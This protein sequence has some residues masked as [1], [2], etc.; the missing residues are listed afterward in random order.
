MTF[1]YGMTRKGKDGKYHFVPYSF[2][3]EKLQKFLATLVE[4][5]T[6]VG[7]EKETKQRTILQ[8]DYYWGGI[9][10]PIMDWTG[11]TKN[12]VHEILGSEFLIAYKLINGKEKPYIR[13]TTDL[14]TAEFSEYSE[15]CRLWVGKEFPDLYIMTPDEYKKYNKQIKVL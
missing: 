7:I 9:V 13:S 2:E 12:E 3:K 15:N 5:P 10:K 11:Y 4:K 6:Q 8:N 14:N 1:F